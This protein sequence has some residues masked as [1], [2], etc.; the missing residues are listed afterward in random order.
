MVASLAGREDARRPASAQLALAH[1]RVVG[2]LELLAA[3]GGLEHHLAQEQCLLPELRL[4]RLVLARHHVLVLLLVEAETEPRPALER[5]LQELHDGVHRHDDA[6]VAERRG[7]RKSR[8]AQVLPQRRPRRVVL[9]GAGLH[10]VH[11]EHAPVPLQAAAQREGPRLG[12]RLGEGH[13][14]EPRCG[15]PVKEFREVLR[16]P[17]PQRVAAR[18][19]GHAAHVPAR[20]RVEELLHDRRRRERVPRQRIARYMG[21]EHAVP[22]PEDQLEERVP[23]AI[24]RRHVSLATLRPAQ[25]Q[26]VLGVRRREPSLAHPAGE[27]HAERERPDRRQ[28]RDDHPFAAAR[29][30]PPGEAPARQLRC[31]AIADGPV[32]QVDLRQRVDAPQ[33]AGELIG[34]GVARRCDVGLHEDAQKLRPLACLHRA[35][36]GERRV[37]HERSQEHPEGRRVVQLR[38]G[39]LVRHVRVGAHV[40]GRAVPAGV[41]HHESAERAAPQPLVPVEDIAVDVRPFVVRPIRAVHDAQRIAPAEPPLGVHLAQTPRHRGV[42]RQPKQLAARE[43]PEGERE[44]QL[45]GLLDAA[46]LD[47]R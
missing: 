44:E 38:A 18:Q 4:E 32:P 15:L 3:R 1:L 22:G 5:H 29:R 40:E 31:D 33:H 20:Q 43:A 34:L 8:Q 37:G 45:D 19:R 42:H 21:E 47:R 28:R 25:I 36:R 30:R 23:V 27:D 11:G 9:V 13:R 12:A 41:A 14:A 35:L 46:R 26:R 10:V 24:A 6:P 39:H 7:G 2:R 17:A 16:V